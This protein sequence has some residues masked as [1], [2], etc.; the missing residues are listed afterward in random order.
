MKNFTKQILNK[1]LF[2]PTRW[3]LIAL[4][5]LLGTSGAL[6]YNQSAVDLYFDNSEAKWS[7]CYVYI[8]HA[9][10]TSCYA[11]TRVSGTQ[12]LWKLAS[13]FNGG[14]AWNGATGWVVSMEKWWDNAGESIDKYV[15]HGD[16]NA[17]KKRTS[18]WSASNIYKTNGTTSVTS[19]G[20]TK[21]V[22]NTT[23]TTKSN[24]TVTIN[25]ATGGTLTVK[26]YD[27]NAVSNGASKIYLTVLK[28]SASA[29]TGYA[30]KE[31]Q[32]NN[33]SSTT[34][35]SAADLASTTYT[36]K[37]AV[38]ITPVWKANT[39]TITYK[40]Q[41]NATFSGA[42]ASGYPT[43][44]TYGT[45]TTLK[46]A[47]KT[48]YDFKGWFT[49]SDCSGTAITSLGAT[50]Y[51]ANIT[52]YAKWEKSCTT[53]NE[54]DVSAEE[55]TICAGEKAVL[56]LNTRQDG[57]TYT[58]GTTDEIFNGTEAYTSDALY[59][60]ISYT[61]TA[62][63]K[64]ACADQTKKIDIKVDPVSKLE[65]TKEAETICKGTSLTLAE[66]VD[67][68]TTGT[69]S[70][71]TDPQMATPATATV[72]P[73]V[74][75]TYYAK[76]VSGVCS[77]ATA[78]LKVTVNDKPAKPTLTAD[79]ASLVAPNMARLTVGNTTNGLTYTLYNGTNEVASKTST[80][81]N[82][83]FEVGD[84]GSYTVKV[85]NDCGTSTSSP[86]EITVCTPI[87][88][89][90]LYFANSSYEKLVEC[91]TYCAGDKAYFVLEFEGD[92]TGDKK[93]EYNKTNFASL[94]GTEY[95]YSF[96][97]NDAGTIKV[98]I[99]TCSGSVTTNTLTYPAEKVIL[100]PATPQLTSTAITACNSECTAMGYI[101]ITNMADYNDGTYTFKLGSSD[102]TPDA[103]GNLGINSTAYTQYT[104]TVTNSCGKTASNTVDIAINDKTPTISGKTITQP[105]KDN[106]IQ[107]TLPTGISAKW[108]VEPNN[109]DLSVN[110]GNSTLFSADVENDY[111]I[112]ANNDGCI[113][114]HNVK[115][116]TAFLIWVRR[117]MSDQSS[118]ENIYSGTS[119]KG[120]ALYL[121][122]TTSGQTYTSVDNVANRNS[123]A[124]NK[125]EPESSYTDCEGAT[126]DIFRTTP[127]MA[128]AGAKF[129]VA[130]K[131]DV[132]TN[133][134]ATYTKDY[135]FA[136]GMTAD[137]YFTIGGHTSGN[138][139]SEIV[140]SEQPLPTNVYSS[141]DA[142]FNANNF[143]DFVPLYVVDCSGNEVDSYQW[144]FSA[145]IDGTYTNYSSECSY[146]GKKT[147][148]TDAG[149]SNN[150][151]VKEAGYYRC[152]VTYKDGKGTSTS[153]SIKVTNTTSGTPGTLSFT[154]E[155]P[156]IMVNTNDLGFPVNDFG[157]SP[158]KNA[159]KM[160]EKM[161]VDVKI[162]EGSTL[163]YDRKAR[164]NYRGS[165]SLNFLKKSYAF[166]PGK[167]DC[168]EDKG[169]KDYV[170]TEKLNM[171]GIGKAVDKDWV[172]YAA[173]A[174]PSL[175]RNR[176]MF[177]TF[178]DMTG[179]WSVSSRYVELVVNGEYKGVYVMM[180]KITAN[181]DRVNVEWKLDDNGNTTQEAFIVKFDKTDKADRY[182]ITSGDQKT[183]KS[184]Y[185]GHDGFD[186]YD[187]NIDQ[188]FEVEYPEKEDIEDGKGKWSE[189]FN[190][191]ENKINK[192]EE[193]LA[194][195]NFSEVQKLIDYTSW[196]DWFIITEFAKN[197]DGYRAS[198]IFVY[199]GSKANAKIEARP[200]WDQELSFDNQCPSYYADYGSNST[201]GLLIDKS[202][203]AVYNNDASAPFWFTG[204]YKGDRGKYNGSDQTFKGLLDDPCFVAEVQAR[205]AKHVSGALS[206]AT[207]TAK[208]TEYRSDLGDIAT[209]GTPMNRELTFWK[210]KSRATID[211]G[212]GSGCY[213]GT[214][215]YSAYNTQ[216]SI[217][218]SATTLT[219]W[220]TGNR[221]AN[222]GNIINGWEGTGLNISLTITPET[223][224]TTPWEAVMVQVNNPSGY[225][226]DLE[227]TTNTL[228]KVSGVIINENND[229]YTYRIP[230]PEAWKPGDEEKDGERTDIQYGIKATLKVGEGVAQCGNSSQAP[231]ATT[232]ITLQD[233]ANENCPK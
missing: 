184:K 17:T 198:N 222:L 165:S 98:S 78:S 204:K 92:R 128:L 214:T 168:V 143:A 203:S 193:E 135:T 42:H 157:G 113:D 73:I 196:A 216:E 52:L 97:I 115:V 219:N 150:I 36:L 175:M 94:T 31:V 79:N 218:N 95:N 53:I 77:A 38:T 91:P 84:A 4:M 139:G 121:E 221:R 44:H 114:T 45:A 119:E 123:S 162:Y 101:T 5:F 61:I 69:V 110:E 60:D 191:I 155:L 10:Y 85:A 199:D 25:S 210:N 81:S 102:V 111:V 109:A 68:S 8:G 23:T 88:T 158:S 41:G 34:T 160:K 224:I 100:P 55:T 172:L 177:D 75:T 188:R 70:W 16:K 161:S 19:D 33:G 6:A 195:G 87:Q 205:W 166:C 71:Y 1:T 217:T 106:A 192:F 208:V 183:F 11:M 131:N 136:N 147:E 120:S 171:L 176:L 132:K 173:A 29:S 186:T 215:G 197:I 227:Y 232:T 225:D 207:M 12:Y 151:R 167:A 18:A 116:S 57:V 149:K 189:V 141:G 154:S 96:T 48:D 117:P 213:D 226:Y 179:G 7:N 228:D 103:D 105:G 159:D 231:S 127:E 22:Y 156:I 233:E 146:V 201:S 76:A 67:Q 27:N 144:Q 35:I 194:K 212:T 129:Y 134:Y 49:K 148:T 202:N 28:F 20:T 125:I 40:D 126:W 50:A 86:I 15:W 54:P 46:T 80:G 43:T 174:D 230:R 185:S 107:L 37:S 223:G 169:R 181:K 153:N 93:W 39:Y 178:A 220:L 99:P 3:L 180:D 140:L 2:K 112:T 137:A 182:E 47:T 122:Q 65:L 90:T 229:K 142:K 209:S 163:K 130:A 30:F 152:I 145:T 56:K 63:A 200:L 13:S 21:T 74:N 190:A 133:G 170:K 58:I 108:S 118:Y 64:D 138:K 9:S 211:C 206:Q 66:Y 32:I 124:H 83:T 187:T 59:D 24:Y 62:T 72:S 14:S 26:D 51:T 164:M 104:V 82:L 89:A